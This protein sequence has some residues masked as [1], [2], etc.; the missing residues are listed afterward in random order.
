MKKRKKKRKSLSVLALD[1][2]LDWMQTDT[3]S[4]YPREFVSE[5]K[6]RTR[7]QETGNEKEAAMARLAGDEIGF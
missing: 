1:L 2:T 7:A 5:D 3:F 4:R 6:D